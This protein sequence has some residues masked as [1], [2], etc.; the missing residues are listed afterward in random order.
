MDTS[1]FRIKLLLK[2][3]SLLLVT[4]A[5]VSQVAHKSLNDCGGAVSYSR[6]FALHVEG[7]VFKS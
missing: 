2:L 6:A 4:A 3:I 1:V 5:Q 7:F